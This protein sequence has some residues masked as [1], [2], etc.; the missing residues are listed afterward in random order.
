LQ[1][2]PAPPN[3][4]DIRL[5]AELA[6]NKLRWATRESLDKIKKKSVTHQV[7]I[8]GETAQTEKLKLES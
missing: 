5:K 8:D 6:G 4:T 1:F 7:S 2:S 3:G